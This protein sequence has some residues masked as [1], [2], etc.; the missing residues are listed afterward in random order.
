MRRVLGAMSVFV[1]GCVGADGP[2]GSAG[3]DSVRPGNDRVSGGWQYVSG[4]L[5]TGAKIDAIRYAN[6]VVDGTGTV[7]VT[8]PGGIKGCAPVTFAVLDESVVAVDI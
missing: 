8:S 1:Y 2:P 4:P 5:V 7:F 3:S 6:L